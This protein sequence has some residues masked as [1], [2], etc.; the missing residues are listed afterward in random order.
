MIRVVTILFLLMCLTVDFVGGQTSDPRCH[1]STEGKEFW[2]GFME[3]RNNSGNK[4]LEIT[5]TAREDAGFSIYIGKSTT[6]F[7]TGNVQANNSV[8]VRI[9]K[10]LA[11]PTGSETIQEKGIRLVAINL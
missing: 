9:P 4:Y 7:Y 11:E 2:F 3:G 8:Q 5:V 10:N 1:R 6:S